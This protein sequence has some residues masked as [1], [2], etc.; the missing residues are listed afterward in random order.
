M[1][2][3]EEAVTA[4]KAI[5][6]G[7]A[8]WQNLARSQFV[9]HLAIFVS[10]VLRSALWAVE[11]AKQEFF[12]STAVNDSSILAHVEDREYLPTPPIPASGDVT[13]TNKGVNPVSIPEGWPWLGENQLPYVTTGAAVI[14]A[15]ASAVIAVKQ[16]GKKQISHIVTDQSPFYQVEFE[17]APSSIAAI[18][19]VIASVEWTLARLFQNVL[20]GSLVYDRY[21]NHLGKTGVRFGNGTFGAMPDKDTVVEITLD[22]TVGES[23]LVFGKK[24]LSSDVLLDDLGAV[25]NVEGVAAETLAGGSNFETIQG[26]AQNLR[27]WP[28]YDQKLVWSDDYTFYFHRNVPGMT[29]LK[30]WGEEEEEAES[31]PSINNVNRIFA[32]AYHPTLADVGAAIEAAFLASKGLNRRFTYRAPALQVFTLAITGK[33]AKTRSISEVT[34]SIKALLLD[35]YGVDVEDRKPVVLL[36][37]IYAAIEKTGYFVE[38]KAYFEV[39]LGGTT[40]ATA[41]N[42]I[43]LTNDANITCTLTYL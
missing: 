21:F 13:F 4:F 1:I 36:K 27:Y 9:E 24:L 39:A 25:A 19:V 15:G 23:T 3:K 32:S 11:R 10:W 7:K 8:A 26:I 5:I 6:S 20:G 28:L 33:L 30:V 43:I 38:N 31:G 35:M 12:L 22:L 17:E 41:L 16:V 37:D 14:A 2:T 34:A 29:W 42:D 40:V 18:T